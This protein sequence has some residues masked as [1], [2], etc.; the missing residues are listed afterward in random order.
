M[1]Q[2]LEAVEFPDIEPQLRPLMHCV[3]LVYANSTYYNSP[4][5]IIVLL[6]ETCNLL[7]DAARKYID[8]TSLFQVK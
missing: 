8:P 6:Q 4:A 2:T 5:R 3:C 7:I 1:F